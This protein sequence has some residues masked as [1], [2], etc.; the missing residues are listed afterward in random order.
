MNPVDSNHGVTTRMH[1]NDE[2]HLKQTLFAAIE[3]DASWQR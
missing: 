1:S 3:T 2:E